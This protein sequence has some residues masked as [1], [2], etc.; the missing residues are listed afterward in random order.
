MKTDH[1][2]IGRLIV[3]FLSLLFTQTLWAGQNA[4]WSEKLDNHLGGHF[5]FKGNITGYDNGSY[6]QPLGTSTGFDGLANTRL[7]D[8]LILS[9]IVYV[10]THY[11]AFLKFGNTYEKQYAGGRS[12]DTSNIDK[13]R[14]FDLTQT[15]KETADY[16]L[17]HRLDRLLL[18]IKPSWGDII[19][20]RQA[21]T[22]GNGLIFNPMDLFNP[23]SPS[24]TNR[25]Y[26]MGDDLVSVR[27]TT[28]ESGEFNLLYV[29]R[30]DV[31]TGEIDFKSS[32]IAGKNHFFIGD[33]EM[34]VMGALHYNETVLG[35]GASG[36]LGDAAWRWDLVW[37]TI[38]KGNRHKNGYIEVVLNMDYSWVWFKKNIY[39][40]IEYYHNGLGKNNYTNALKDTEV[41][42]R[43]DRGESFALGKNYV[44]LQIQVELH[45]LFNVYV[46]VINNFRDPSGIIQPRAVW[47]TTQNSNIQLGAN[48]YYG[49]PGSE[50]GGFLIPDTI[51]H[52]NA[53]PSA[54]VLFTTYF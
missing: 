9:E 10:Q 17:W 4:A 2:S 44:S 50:Y 36:C 33:M 29:P 6:F 11:E 43:I 34:D 3:F 16:I 52:T 40:L 46:N 38:K 45:P 30:R 24:D 18:S 19:V 41:V 35:L 1:D 53:A 31:I 23:F 42:E 12:P 32:S 26:K 49:R 51:H 8:K 15:V 7:T 14:I 28:Q 47:N 13:R 37:S 5:K 48:F 39:G 54:Y 20:G 27:F 25:D 22:W 21:V